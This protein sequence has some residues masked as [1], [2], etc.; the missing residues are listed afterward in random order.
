MQHLKSF[1]QFTFILESDEVTS[2]KSS[3]EVDALL[4]DLDKSG[5]N[6]EDEKIQKDLLDKLIDV[7]FNTD[8]IDIENIKEYNG[9]LYEGH[10]SFGVL[11]IIAEYV[12]NVELAERIAHNLNIDSKYVKKTFEVVSWIVHKASWLLEQVEKAIFKIANLMGMSIEQ[13]KKTATGAMAILGICCFIYGLTHIT[14]SLGAAVGIGLIIKILAVC[15]KGWAS[16]KSFVIKVKDILHESKSGNYTVSDFLDDIKSRIQKMGMVD[17]ST[18]EV[19]SLDK[20]YDNSKTEQNKISMLLNKLSK[21]IN[22]EKFNREEIKKDLL[23]L[24]NLIDKKHTDARKFFH[25]LW[26]TLT[27][28][29]RENK[30]T[31][32]KAT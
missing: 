8:K 12:D 32:L 23:K 28:S 30:N 2:R 6:I 16:I 9:N 10:G 24:I 13:S 3:A 26:D 29:D 4:K 1:E 17:I 15:F 20:W 5:K 22:S 18:S 25:K 11:H 21:K 31:V 14:G 27:K 19:F 7:N